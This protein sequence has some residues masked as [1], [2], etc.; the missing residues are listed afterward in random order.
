M[1]DVKLGL[2]YNIFASGIRTWPTPHIHCV[3]PWKEDF[4]RE[5]LSYLPPSDS[6]TPIDETGRVTK[7][8]YHER[9]VLSHEELLFFPFWSDMLP[10]VFDVEFARYMISSFYTDQSVLSKEP[11]IDI[12]LVRDGGGY[13]IGPHTDSPRRILSMIFYLPNPEE[14]SE[15]GTALYLPKKR[16]LVSEK[17]SHYGFEGFDPVWQAPYQMN[18]VFVF[19]RTNTSWHGVQEIPADHAPRNLLLVDFQH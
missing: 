3:N 15:Y 18:S 5:I 16:D 19:K 2:L 10:M 7:G 4:Y 12:L 9:K 11:K 8:Q 13:A 14:E 6:Y 1:K 17:G